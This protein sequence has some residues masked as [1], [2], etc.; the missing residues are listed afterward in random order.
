M[1]RMEEVKKRRNKGN[2]VLPSLA[3]KG[4]REGQGVWAKKGN[5]IESLRS[6]QLKNVTG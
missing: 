5:T 6:K 2:E 1:K 3:T 4:A